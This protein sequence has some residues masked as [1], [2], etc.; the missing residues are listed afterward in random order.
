[1]LGH[2]FEIC[3]S[4]NLHSHGLTVTFQLYWWLISPDNVV[5]I[6]MILPT[7]LGKFQ[8]L[9]LVG[10]RYHGPISGPDHS[11]L[12]RNTKVSTYGGCTNVS[13]KLSRYQP[14][15]FKWS[16]LVVFL[17]PPHQIL[18][19]FASD[20]QGPSFAKVILQ[21]TILLQTKYPATNCTTS[22]I[23]S[24][25]MQ[26]SDNGRDVSAFFPQCDGPLSIIIRQLHG[27]G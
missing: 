14:L 9:L 10:V 23:S 25:L 21:A 4:A 24:L 5:Q 19:N 12:Q 27:H 2:R 15:Q 18:R 8:P 3:F 7:Y 20:L 11:P 1:M 6:V 13:A 16:P 17:Q 26:S 22:G